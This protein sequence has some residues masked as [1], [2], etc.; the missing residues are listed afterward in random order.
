MSN[1]I[2]YTFESIWRQFFTIMHYSYIFVFTTIDT[3]ETINQKKKKT[4]REK[5][6][7]KNE[8]KEII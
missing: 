8:N 7:S 1:R 5:K 6:N 2:N 3:I 4:C